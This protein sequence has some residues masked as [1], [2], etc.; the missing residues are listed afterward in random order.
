MIT[1]F[2]VLMVAVVLTT[3]LHAAFVAPKPKD[4]RGWWWQITHHIS[5]F[6]A[7]PCFVLECMLSDFKRSG[8]ITAT[9]WLLVFGTG[10]SRLPNYLHSTPNAGTIQ[11]AA[12]IIVI[13]SI[14]WFVFGYIILAVLQELEKPYPFADPF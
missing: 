9:L 6:I 13:G 3:R 5:G 10:I 12:A 11:Q 1:F 14:A 4:Q 2:I 7:Y 8:L